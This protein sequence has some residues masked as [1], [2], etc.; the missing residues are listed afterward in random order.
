[1]AALVAGVKAIAP[2]FLQPGVGDSHPTAPHLLKGSS[3][4]LG[5]SLEGAIFEKPALFLSR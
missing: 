4:I 1:M 2:R 5:V 3:S